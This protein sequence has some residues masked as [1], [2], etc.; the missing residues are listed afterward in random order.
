MSP[1][2]LVYMANQIGRFFVSQGPDEAVAGTLDHI[3]MFW[4][5][6]MRAGI[7]DYL[8]AGGE[9]LSPNVRAA[10]EMLKAEPVER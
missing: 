7:V 6:R 2:R 10:V 3:R 9:G 4:D 8:D 1:E 5:P